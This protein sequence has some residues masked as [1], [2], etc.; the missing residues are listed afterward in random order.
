MQAVY[1]RSILSLSAERV[2]KTVEPESCSL[3]LLPADLETETTQVGDSQLETYTS[4]LVDIFLVD[5]LVYYN[6]WC[7]VSEAVTMLSPGGPDWT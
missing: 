2:E 7:Q 5:R 1:T 6:Q 3:Q 4:G